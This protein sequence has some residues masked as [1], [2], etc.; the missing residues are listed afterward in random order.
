MTSTSR[1]WRNLGVAAGAVTA[2]LFALFD[3]YQ[4]AV[5][6]ASDQFHNDFTFYYAAARIGLAHG[7]AAIYDLGL[8]QAELAAMGSGI[9]IAELARFISPPPV[10]WAALPLTAL[11]YPVAYWVWSLLLVAALVATWQL[12]AP[13]SGLAR[14]ILLAAAT[15]W[16]PV[17]YG[18]QLGQPAILVAFGVAGSYALLRAGHPVWAGIALAPLALKPQLAFLVPPALLAA[19]QNRAFFGSVLALGLLAA[20]SALALGGP[21]V[22]TYETRLAFAAGVPVNRE[23]TL[24]AWLGDLTLT[25]GVQVAIALWSLLL[26]YRMRRRGPEWI[27]VPAL[28][29]GLLA[30]PYLHLDDLLVLGLAAWLFLRTEN[31]G[32]AWVYVLALVIAVEGEPFWG[33]LPVVAGELGALL[34]ISVASLKADDRD[35]E[36]HETEPEHD[37]R[38][39]RD[40][41]HVVVDGQ[42]QPVDQPARQS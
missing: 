41:E 12:A 28:L 25:R 33:P 9:H 29:G 3:L 10:A 27:F 20:A 38:L 17:I 2:V 13:G 4:W 40:G 6:F 36:H 32:W 31:L 39:E 14:L 37:A 30:S 7:W 19:R 5:A 26:V 11:P 35:P 8:Q 24:A 1:R 34:L 21:G 15:G 23:L 22:A 18:L 16:L 42:R